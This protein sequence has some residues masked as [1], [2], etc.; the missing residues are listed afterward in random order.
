MVQTDIRRVWVRTAAGMVAQWQVH[1]WDFCGGSF[2]NHALLPVALWI[3]VSRRLKVRASRWLYHLAERLRG[4][5][6]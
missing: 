5:L 6:P 1:V 3:A 4:R 2:G